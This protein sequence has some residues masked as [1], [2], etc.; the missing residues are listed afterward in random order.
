LEAKLERWWVGPLV[1]AALAALISV[2]PMF[3]PSGSIDLGPLDLRAGSSNEVEF[4]VDYPGV[5]SI[6]VEMDQHVAKRL[7]PCMADMEARKAGKPV[8][9]GAVTARTWPL[10]LAL[11]LAAD[12]RDESQKIRFAGA[13]GGAYT[14][15]ATY[16]WEAGLADMRR[17]AHY[18]LFARPLTDAT[19]LAST[20]PRLVVW[21]ADPGFGDEQTLYSVATSALAVLMGLG[22]IIWSAAALW[23]SRRS[24]DAI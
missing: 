6:G 19:V 10:K 5:Y 3:R 20:H 23:A 9:D 7:F 24:P 22:A 8:C 21:K 17:D 4:Q 16:T 15:Q 14:G 12:G 18:R 13:E 1:L 2:L 11:K